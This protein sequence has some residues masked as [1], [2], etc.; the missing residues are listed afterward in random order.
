[1][2]VER[3]TVGETSLEVTLRFSAE[4]PLRTSAFPDLPERALA[5]LPGLR[6]HVCD[7]P[8]GRSL[9]EELP[10]TELA[11]V[12]EHVAVELAALAGSPR[13]LRGETAWDFGR[14]GRGVFRVTLA[15]DDD[16]VALGAVKSAARVMEWLCDEG[17]A[18]AIDAE[19]A[20]LR[21]VRDGRPGR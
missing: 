12:F 4:E 19:V 20:R 13:T 6:R 15:Y 18:L 10:D 21:A 8:D 1:V 9:A 17:D 3:V 11:H 7:N 5:L 14:D 16:L 2:R